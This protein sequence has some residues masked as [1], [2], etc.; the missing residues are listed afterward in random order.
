MAAISF[1]RQSS[2][3][4]D[5]GPLTP[6]GRHVR[7]QLPT[8]MEMHNMFNTDDVVGLGFV[9]ALNSTTKIYATGLKRHS[10]WKK[11]GV[12]VGNGSKF[13][14]DSIPRR[15]K[16]G[17]APRRPST[18]HPRLL[19]GSSRSSMKDLVGNLGTV[20]N[21]VTSTVTAPAPATGSAA[22]AA[23]AS[24]FADE[25]NSSP[26]M[27]RRSSILSIDES[28]SSSATTPS[29]K[30]TP[31]GSIMFNRAGS[32]RSKS[33]FGP[34]S[35]EGRLSRAGSM[36]SG[37]GEEPVEP[38]QPVRKNTA[39]DDLLHKRLL[40]ALNSLKA[41]RMEVELNY[42][43]PDDLEVQ[44][45]L[46][47]NNETN[48]SVN[49]RTR[50]KQIN[51]ML[52]MFS[53]WIKEQ[54]EK[55]HAVQS[56]KTSFKPESLIDDMKQCNQ[57]YRSVMR[58]VA[59]ASGP[60]FARLM[61][62]IWKVVLFVFDNNL[63]HYR[64]KIHEIEEEVCEA[65]EQERQQIR[66]ENQDLKFRNSQLTSAAAIIQAKLDASFDELK[67]DK[68][69]LRTRLE[70]AEKT[71]AELT[72]TEDGSKALNNVSR[73]MHEMGTFF[74]QV[75]TEQEQQM[76][77]LTEV[78][79]FFSDLGKLS[80]QPFQGLIGL[81]K[82]RG[83]TMLN[84]K[85]RHVGEAETQTELHMQDLGGAYVNPIVKASRGRKEIEK[86]L[87]V[88]STIRLISDLL[89]DTTKYIESM[90]ASQVTHGDTF[91]YP[92]VIIE[93]FYK[94]SGLRSLAYNQ[95]QLFYESVQLHCDSNRFIKLFAIMLGLCER[96]RPL[97][98]EAVSTVVQARKVFIETAVK[99]GKSLTG[100][101]TSDSIPLNTAVEMVKAA[102]PQ[103]DCHS[104]QDLADAIAV[105]AVV[106]PEFETMDPE[107]DL[108]LIRT[109][110]K[111][112]SL[113]GG[114]LTLF[115][116]SAMNTTVTF[117]QF[118]NQF[119][120]INLRFTDDQFEKLRL[121]L[122]PYS[123]DIFQ[124]SDMTQ[125]VNIENYLEMRN[126]F[127]VSHISLLQSALEMWLAETESFKIKRMDIF[128]RHDNNQ[129]TFT[130]A[131]F[132]DMIHELNR[133]LDQV[134]VGRMFR[135]AL[136]HSNGRN[137]DQITVEAFLYVTDKY[138]TGQVSPLATSRFAAGSSSSVLRDSIPPPPLGS[139]AVKVSP[140]KSIGRPGSASAS[141]RPGSA[142]TRA[143]SP[144][145]K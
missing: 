87:T 67:K 27:S 81:R 131:D 111:V 135:E 106:V 41:L 37:I 38:L 51:S 116:G 88:S 25:N 107:M 53:T 95:I 79:T 17:E 125:R 136:D 54:V 11:D 77:A 39:E 45:E 46:T 97:P 140:S 129:G 30:F 57:L 1:R 142:T 16:D 127:T 43:V 10:A 72:R 56:K 55:A 110:Q 34:A 120:A 5:A 6:K 144:G 32:F 109:V 13:F 108:I 145:K 124:L 59:N 2:L 117:E 15:S 68:E 85:G 115:G 29:P 132:T 52:D 3:V 138:R 119:I 18:A 31:R 36:L 8:S 96:I 92:D 90:D 49:L 102:F 83:A 24:N 113:G 4:P 22:A 20:T 73:L 75:E 105:L 50:R 74:D 89:S 58:A 76:A 99:S 94:Q 42:A 14:G 93:Y 137:A 80:E 23:G 66:L 35:V 61:E 141:R 123:T 12:S 82:K 62:R 100:D 19:R 101:P 40:G 71:I 112:T 128:N 143:K 118:K 7:V 28:V 103:Y 47:K 104:N 44:Y 91:S 9:S 84:S 60:D 98:Y 78:N 121:F 139:K 133:E 26:P 65:F 122:D 69:R 130:L 70:G 48:F 64:Q 63:S 33:L 134:Q 114:L 21:T 126:K 86:P